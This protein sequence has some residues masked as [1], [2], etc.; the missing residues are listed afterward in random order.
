MRLTLFKVLLSAFALAMVSSSS[1]AQSVNVVMIVADDMGYADLGVTGCKDFATPRIDSIAQS[2]VR[3]TRA[4][5]TAAVCSPSRAGFITGQYQQ[6]FGHEHNGSGPEPFG[7]PT[8]VTT[9][10]QHFRAAGYTTGL[11]GKW[12]LGESPG[13]QP[14]DRGFDWF[15]G[16]LEG[17]HKYNVPSD[18]KD[19]K[20]N[21]ILDGRVPA[22]WNSYLTTYFGERSAEFIRIN[23]KQPFF[24]YLS[25]NAP[26]TPMQPR[27]TDM[28]ALAH[29]KDERRRKYASMMLAMDEAV[30]KV[31]DQLK[32][33]GVYDNTLIVFFSDNGGPQKGDPSAN[34]SINRP[35]RSGKAQT[36]EGGIRVPMLMSLPGVISP[37]SIYEK[38]VSSLDLLPTFMAAIGKAPIDGTTLD[39]VN[40]LPFLAGTHT[41]VP[42]ERLYWRLGASMAMI[43][44]DFKLVHPRREGGLEANPER[45]DLSKTEL[46]D[47][48][49]DPSE[50]TNLAARDLRRHEQMKRTWQEWESTLA[51][52]IW[53]TWADRQK[54]QQ[55]K[56]GAETEPSAPGAPSD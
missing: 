27:E 40:L 7:L 31:I 13:K 25:F 49:K 6:R 39:G 46:Y 2:G 19:P 43:E 9:M 34:G 47:L 3:F 1:V 38:P 53:G 8:N 15:V 17:G 28:A 51:K 36:H 23:S 50:T 14:L 12:H 48:S 26:H 10:P 42:H 22:K 29:I 45:V 52:P 24:L 55:V 44:G 54:A 37:G 4:Y 18:L 30:G 56:R 20:Q 11:V 21:K 16:H 5:V 33:E 32:A 41:G 35:L